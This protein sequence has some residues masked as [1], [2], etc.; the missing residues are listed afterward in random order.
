MKVLACVEY[1][2]T[3]NACITQAWMD[4]PGLIPPLPVE[5]GLL[6]SGYMVT[7][8]MSAW[9]FKALRRFLNPRI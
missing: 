9:G 4:Q 3:T 5:Q 7:I 2:T 8:A 1:D 6:L